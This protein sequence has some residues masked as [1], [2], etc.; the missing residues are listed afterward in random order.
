MSRNALSRF[1]AMRWS[2]GDGDWR[3]RDSQLFLALTIVIGV[4]AG[5]SAVLFALSIDA[6]GHFFFGAAPSTARIIL[7]PTLVSLVSGVLL[8]KYFTDVR[9]SGV[10]Q[11]KAAYL[12][13]LGHIR[14]RVTI[15]KF[16]MGVLCIGSG[17]ARGGEGPS[18]L[19]GAGVE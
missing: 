2:L 1:W 19:I 18:G 9:G 10:P 8:T 3:L 13:R 4:L 17:L 15:G 16:V 5:L 14:A 11:T 6:A 7:V 12:L